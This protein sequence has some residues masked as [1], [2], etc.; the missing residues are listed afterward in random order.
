M[1][2]I[3]DTDICPFII[4]IDISQHS[5]FL[6]IIYNCPIVAFLIYM[7]PKSNY[8]LICLLI[9]KINPKFRVSFMLV[10]IIFHS[11]RCNPSPFLLTCSS[12][13]FI[14]FNVI[15]FLFNQE[16]QQKYGGGKFLNSYI[17][18]QSII[19]GVYVSCHNKS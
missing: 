7:L 11:G 14:D 13:F 1:V 6:L 9:F 2:L 18:T 12:F 4:S 8:L 5:H 15:N 16:L 19:Q 3:N 17:E 10:F